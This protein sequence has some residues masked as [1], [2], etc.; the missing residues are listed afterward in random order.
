[1]N[2]TMWMQ[3]TITALI[4]ILFWLAIRRRIEQQDAII[5]G[6][7]SEAQ[8]MSGEITT[9]RDERV[10]RIE[11]D[12]KGDENKRKDIYHRIEAVELG[13]MSKADCA[14]EHRGQEQQRAEFIAAVLKL[15]RVGKDAERAVSWLS[16]MQKEQTNLAREVSGLISRVESIEHRTT[17]GGK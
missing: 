1:M 9:L 6:Y 13:Y 2:I 11:S 7:K 10:E 12:I 8:K 3:A 14:R 17:N 4:Q 16:E 15:E 5:A